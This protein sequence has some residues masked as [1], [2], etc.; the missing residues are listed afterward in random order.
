MGKKNVSPRN[1]SA[2]D[3]STAT[4]TSSIFSINTAAASKRAK[5]SRNKADGSYQVRDHETS[6]HM[7][8][9]DRR[10]QRSNEHPE[11]RRI[12]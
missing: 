9:M 7:T 2:V 3:R 1:N 4:E 5:A 12:E 10:S 8:E 11:R 6:E